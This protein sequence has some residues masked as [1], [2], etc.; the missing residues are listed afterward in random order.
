MATLAER[1]QRKAI[2]EGA[3]DPNVSPVVEPNLPAAPRQDV[4]LEDYSKQ[5]VSTAGQ[6]GVSLAQA[7]TQIKQEEKIKQGFLANTRKAW[8]R[9]DESVNIDFLW[10]SVLG[11]HTSREEAERIT[12]EFQ[13]RVEDDPIQARNW[14]EKLWLKTVV[15]PIQRCDLWFYDRWSSGYSWSGWPS[16]SHT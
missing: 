14:A 8:E 10:A 11:G 4:S 1:L 16:D 2:S 9:A 13:Q 5:V 15:R 6:Q 12:S 7:E 3:A